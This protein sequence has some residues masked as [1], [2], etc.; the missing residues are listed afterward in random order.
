MN[1][2]VPKAFQDPLVASLAIKRLGTPDDLVPAV[3]FLLS[4]EA[5]WMTGHI[6]AVDG[7]QVTRI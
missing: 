2:Q 7:G 1:K 6:V 3:L 5:R 4:E